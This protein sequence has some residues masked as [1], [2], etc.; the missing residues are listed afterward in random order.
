MTS[1]RKLLLFSAPVVLVLVVL[2]AKSVSVVIAGQG[3][4]TAYADRNTAAL[5]TAVDWLR[6]LD[7]AEPAKT[8]FAAG[9]LAVLDGRPDE[10]ERHFSDSLGHTAPADSCAVRVNLELVRETLGDRAGAAFDTRSA[11]DRYRAARTI[12]EQAPPDCFAGNADPDPQRR[13]L[14]ADALARLDRKIAAAQVAPPPPPPAVA[15]GA[16][17]PPATGG[18][19][20]ETPDPLRLRPE[21][22]TPLDRLQQILRDAAAQDGG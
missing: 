12:V 13:A 8:S 14:R 11:V 20:V 15:S 22:G 6:L 4:V 19:P 9:D 18:A 17:P 7:I 3:A 21:T 5:R 2:I 10:A 1:R 16:P